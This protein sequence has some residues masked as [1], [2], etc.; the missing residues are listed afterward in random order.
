MSHWQLAKLHSKHKTF[1]II[2][3]PCPQHFIAIS[4]VK[5]ILKNNTLSSC[6]KIMG[7][8]LHIK[9]SGLEKNLCDCKEILD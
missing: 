8:L 1:G 7:I 5:D 4:E 9:E 2:R 6:I 3:P